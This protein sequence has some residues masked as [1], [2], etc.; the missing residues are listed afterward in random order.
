[1][2]GN[3]TSF[4]IISVSSKLFSFI[5]EF[6]YAL[7]FLFRIKQLTPILFISSEISKLLSS[8]TIK[9]I[10]ISFISKLITNQIQAIAI[11]KIKLT[12]IIR[13][14]GKMLYP[15]TIKRIQ[16]GFIFTAIQKLVSSFTI[17]KIKLTF[18]A[19]Y[20]TFYALLLYDPQTLG[21]LD[22]KTLG[23]MDFTIIP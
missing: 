6:D 1:M 2:T 13:E 15:I 4:S 3:K 7:T 19:L 22:S 9:K 11:K 8:F 10:K 18:V 16:L 21:A 20:G 17:K 5:L 14:I 23:E 12:F